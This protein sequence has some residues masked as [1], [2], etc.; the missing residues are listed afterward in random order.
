MIL[1]TLKLRDL[2][3]YIAKLLYDYTKCHNKLHEGKLSLP[4]NLKHKSLRSATF[5]NTVSCRL[6]ELYP[7]V[8]YTYGYETKHERHQLGLEKSHSRKSA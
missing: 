8:H 2:D 5:M 3:G 6:Q 4:S 7:N 1:K